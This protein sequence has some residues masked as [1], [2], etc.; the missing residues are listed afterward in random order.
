MKVL[1]YRLAREVGQVEWVWHVEPNP[2][3]TGHHVHAWEHGAFVPQA[4]LSDLAASV[5]MGPF[6]RISKIRS[7]LGAGRYGLKGLTYGLKGVQAE[8]EGV[9]YLRA[10]GSRLTHQSRGFF[11]GP[12]GARLSVKAADRAARTSD[13]EG[14]SRW[15]LVRLVSGSVESGL[16]PGLPVRA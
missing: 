6:A 5:G 11:R 2:A 9:S 14:G 3:G 1:R 4:R 15:A 10:N 12:S 16:A 7:S 8:D 13:A